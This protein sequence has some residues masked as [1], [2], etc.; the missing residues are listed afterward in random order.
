MR[1]YGTN[2]G[3]SFTDWHYGVALTSSVQQLKMLADEI[4]K[5]YF[6]QLKRF[7]WS[8]GVEGASDQSTKSPKVYP[9]R[10]FLSILGVARLSLFPSLAKDIYSW[11][12]A[13]ELGKLKVVIIGQD[14][15]HG[16]R[17]AHGLCFSVQKGVRVPPSLKNVGNTATAK[18]ALTYVLC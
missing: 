2:L 5:T 12:R 17:Q 10:M 4:R 9:P 14:P 18:L 15:Y 7:L 6:L 13:T 3:R 16:V 11:S 1:H 8:E